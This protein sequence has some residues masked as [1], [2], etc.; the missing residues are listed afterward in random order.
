MLQH[1]AQHQCII[2]DLKGV[3][4][5][6]RGTQ[7]GRQTSQGNHVVSV[8][9]YSR[10]LCCSSRWTTRLPVNALQGTQHT[11][12]NSIATGMPHYTAAAL[13]TA[14]VTSERIPTAVP[15]RGYSLEEVELH[16]LHVR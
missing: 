8:K 12:N 14:S 7:A 11:P 10:S 5:G 6:H 16:V 15:P 1:L 3:A 4:A 9:V 13:R 2:V